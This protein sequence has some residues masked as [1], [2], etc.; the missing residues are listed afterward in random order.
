MSWEERTKSQEWI[1][2]YFTKEKNFYAR[3]RDRSCRKPY[4][5]VYDLT[6]FKDHVNETH[7]NIYNYEEANKISNKWK[8]FMLTEENAIICILCNIPITEFPVYE[9][10]IKHIK[11]HAKKGQY[12]DRKRH[13]YWKYLNQV[14]DFSAEC[15]LCPNKNKKFNLFIITRKMK[16]HMK[17]HENEQTKLTEEWTYLIEN[18]YFLNKCYAKSVNFRA[19]CRFCKLNFICVPAIVLK[20]HIQEHKFTY[21]AEEI[22]QIGTKLGNNWSYFRFTKNEAID[23]IEC[24]ICKET[25]S[26]DQMENH[27]KTH[28]LQELIPCKFD[29]WAFKYAREEEDFLKCTICDAGMN[30]IAD[31]THLETHMSDKHSENYDKIK[32]DKKFWTFQTAKN[33]WLQK[34]YI[35][36]GDF[37]AECTVCEFKEVYLKKDQFEKHMHD[38]H[39]DIFDKEEIEKDICHYFSDE[40]KCLRHTY[41]MEISRSIECVICHQQDI[42][43][44]HRCSQDIKPYSQH[45]VFK[46]AGR[47]GSNAYCTICGQNINFDYDF[48]TLKN[49]M[50]FEHREKWETIEQGEQIEQQDLEQGTAHDEARPSTSYAS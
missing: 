30:I 1:T 26:N 33:S 42:M 20:T 25:L 18:N 43:V 44:D 39:Y 4:T 8:Y 41:D 31:I 10:L 12:I 7:P 32:Q 35:D 34:C 49:H 24:M 17:V 28:F 19:E 23:E 38:S 14:G 2:A 46:Y 15:K 5:Y 50:S 11:E 40:W 29:D 9:I 21:K 48:D 47:D 37:R 3:C 22:D 13:W 45:W 16:E 6:K 27:A 36:A